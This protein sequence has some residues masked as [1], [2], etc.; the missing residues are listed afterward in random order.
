[1]KRRP[2][3]K[4]YRTLFHSSMRKVNFPKKEVLMNNEEDAYQFENFDII[5]QSFK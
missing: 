1:M 5:G 3:N 4:D 2:K